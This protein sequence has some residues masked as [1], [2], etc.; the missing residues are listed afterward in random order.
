[1]HSHTT[2]SDR[3]STP[4]EVMSQHHDNGTYEILAITDHNTNTWPWSDW[5]NEDLIDH[6]ASSEYYPTLHMLAISG[7]E[8]TIGHH[9]SSL[10]NEC[11]FMGFFPYLS[12][13]FIQKHQGMSVFHHLGRYC[14]NER[15]YQN[16]FNQYQGIISGIEVYNQGGRYQN[17]RLLWDRINKAREPNDLVWGFSNDDFYNMSRDSFRN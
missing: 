9:R 8:L 10:L 3:T 4:D 14:Y 13:Y 6:S 7:N 5:I 2:E 16:F 15:W 1:M 11:S 12:Y 17:D